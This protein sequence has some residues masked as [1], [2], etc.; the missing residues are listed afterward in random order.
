MIRIVIGSEPRLLNILRGVVEFRSQEA[1]LS[2][3]D[4]EC[5]AM[6]IDEAAAN[7]IQ[8][9][10]G[11]RNDAPL[12]LE[13]RRLPDR[14]EFVLEDW[15]P[16]VREDLIR[17]RPL[18]ELRPGGLGTFFIYSFMDECSYDP[19]WKE[20]NRLKLVKFLSRKGACGHDGSSAQ[21]G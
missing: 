4:A 11:G 8:H 18:E 17:P 20:G 1:G 2:K 16:K 9:T 21:S 3:S 14:L 7:V 13:V 10:Y 5:L 15:G 6:A 19:D 12:A